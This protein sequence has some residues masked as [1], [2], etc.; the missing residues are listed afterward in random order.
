MRHERSSAW[1]LVWLYGLL[2]AYASL[3]PFEGWRWPAAAT[4]QELLRLSWPPWR[5]RFDEWSNLLGY[6]PFG[7]FL[8]AAVR[9]GWAGPWLSTLVAVLGGAL[10]SYSME[11]VQHFIP[12][13]FPSLRDVS[14]N[15]LGAAL[16]ALLGSAWYALDRRSRG[17]RWHQRWLL[18]ASGASWVLLALWP[19]GLLFPTPYPLGL[20]VTGWLD[21][22]RE[23]L[24]AAPAWLAQGALAQALSQPFLPAWAADNLEAWV[25]ATGLAAP[26]ALAGMITR[27]G[28]QR[29]L[30]APAIA[31]V[32]VAVMTL[33]TA[34]NF[35]PDHALAWM[36]RLHVQALVAAVL[37][38][39]ALCLLGPR[40][41]AALALLALLAQWLL[42]AEAPQDPYYA[43]SLQGWDQGRFIRFHG[44]AQLIGWVWPYLAAVWVLMHISGD[45]RDLRA[46][47]R[48]G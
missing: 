4:W 44:L 28:W 29:G 6:A 14:N 3:Y 24:A 33:S 20:G 30:L 31:G 38:C 18:P 40:W 19:A 48:K 39:A 22:L 11:L 43:A 8:Y 2:L 5:N 7:L 13:R 16:G 21:D 46:A 27:P 1:P 32:A 41:C 23:L 9:A 15:T 17:K 35:G 25:L 26:C 36:T 34:L 37:V 10:L 42:L 47:W 12:G 45:P